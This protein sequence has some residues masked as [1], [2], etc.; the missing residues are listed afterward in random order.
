MIAG[1]H[2]RWFR[3]SVIA[4]PWLSSGTRV[5]SSRWDRPISPSAWRVPRST[6]RNTWYRSA[7]SPMASALHPSSMAHLRWNP[8]TR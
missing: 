7:R 1:S 2:E 8:T 5:P 6:W 3:L 4:V